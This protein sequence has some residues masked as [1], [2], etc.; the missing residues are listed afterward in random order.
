M[1]IC[2]Q[3]TLTQKLLHFL[4]AHVYVDTGVIVIVDA[5]SAAWVG[6]A[7][8]PFQQEEEKEAPKSPQHRMWP[9]SGLRRAATAVNQPQ[10]SSCCLA[11]SCSPGFR[12]PDFF[13]IRI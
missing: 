11:C 2:P 4:H 13:L 5:R 1:S 6:E 10:H 3:A 8:G 12:I 7:D 9:T